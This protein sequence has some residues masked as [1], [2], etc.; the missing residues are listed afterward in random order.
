MSP[1]SA[2]ACTATDCK[3]ASIFADAAKDPFNGNYGDVLANFA[4]DPNNINAGV[5]PG[6]LTNYLAAAG[7]QRIPLALGL[8][9]NRKFWYTS[10][11][12][13]LTGL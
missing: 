7:S 5:P 10:A 4:I 6:V 3:F 9:I 1:A 13:V 8:L 12:F 11:P 2:L